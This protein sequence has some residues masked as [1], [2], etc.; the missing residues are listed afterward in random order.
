MFD[1]SLSGHVDQPVQCGFH[2]GD[3]RGAQQEKRIAAIDRGVEGGRIEK[4]EVGKL[5]G[6]ETIR[7]LLS[8]AICS[9]CG[10]ADGVQGGDGG[11]SNVA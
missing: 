11:R 8:V 6:G 4:V 7:D 2:A 1:A 10:Y 3:G 9:P 5:G